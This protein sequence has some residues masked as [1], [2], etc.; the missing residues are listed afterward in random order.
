M[1]TYE[2]NVNRFMV[3]QIK[4]MYLVIN[5]NVLSSYRDTI[6]IKPTAEFDTMVKNHVREYVLNAIEPPADITSAILN[7]ADDVMADREAVIR[8]GDYI[9]LINYARKTGIKLL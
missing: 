7:I 9:T 1:A 6:Q 4:I 8:S 5:Q 3:N 2:V